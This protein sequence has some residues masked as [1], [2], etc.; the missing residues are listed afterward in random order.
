MAA[1]GRRAATVTPTPSR[2]ALTFTRRLVVAWRASAAELPARF[3]GSVFSEQFRSRRN[4]IASKRHVRQT[5]V[6]GPGYSYVAPR[7]GRSTT[8]RTRQRHGP[9]C[10]GLERD[11]SGG[12]SAVG[13]LRQQE[14]IEQWQAAFPRMAE[15]T[16]VS[17]D[18]GH[19]LE[20]HRGP[21]IAEGLR[22]LLP[23]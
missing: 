6:W 21:E 18:S 1:V 11:R 16:R 4:A 2:G 7:T 12:P 22:A 13:S 10:R 19:F 8:P 9:S 23:S 3:P 14:V 15:H 20:E 17:P 5:P